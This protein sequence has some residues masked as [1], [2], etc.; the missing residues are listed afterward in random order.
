VSYKVEKGTTLLSLEIP[1]EAAVNVNEVAASKEREQK[2]QK[3]E[4]MDPD[5]SSESSMEKVL[6]KVPFTAC[7][8]KY[9]A[10]EMVENY[11]SAIL[12]IETQV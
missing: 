2:R 1:L 7:L 10:A 8:D 12:G 6:P 9:A 11:R 4:S 5:S 3:F